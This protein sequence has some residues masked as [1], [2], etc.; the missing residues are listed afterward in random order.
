[1]PRLAFVEP[2]LELTAALDRAGV[3]YAVG[4]AIA[5][6]LHAEPRN[7]SDID[8]NIFVPESESGPVLDLMAG[9][10]IAVGQEQREEILRR[11]QTRLH[12]GHLIVDPFFATVPFLDSARQR[13][14][15]V[16]FEGQVIAI[17][18]AEDL[19]IA[20]ILFNR[21]KDWGDL[22]N[23][24]AIQG[25]A[26]DVGYIRSWLHEMLGDEDGRIDR[27]E[28]LLAEVHRQVQELEG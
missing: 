15:K 25:D 23:M 10:G 22:A 6:G 12:W 2:L 14:L 20:K 16:E 9:L 27:F 19:A 8:I 18:S 7:T 26:L 13:R 28:R 4:G 5:Y 3:P 1:M 17:L 24:V 11:G 21:S